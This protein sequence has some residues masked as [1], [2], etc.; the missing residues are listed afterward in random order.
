MRVSVSIF[1]SL[2]FTGMVKELLFIDLLNTVRIFVE[3]ISIDLGLWIK[4]PTP[5]LLCKT[6][7][8]PLCLMH[9]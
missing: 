5:V 6:S 2:I 3:D 1:F 7:P 9:S 8:G 4:N